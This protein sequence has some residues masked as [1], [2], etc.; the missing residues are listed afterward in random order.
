MISS[1][2]LNLLNITSTSTWLLVG[3][4]AMSGNVRVNYGGGLDLKL[5]LETP[6]SYRQGWGRLDLSSSLPLSGSALGW[7]LQVGRK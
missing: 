1:K 3:A 4:M 6:P 7:S 2:R 5:P